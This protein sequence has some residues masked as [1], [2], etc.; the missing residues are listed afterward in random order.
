VKNAPNILQITAATRFNVYVVWWFL[1][2]TLLQIYCPLTGSGAVMRPDSFVILALL[3][4]NRLLT[5]LLP[6]LF[7]SLRIG[8]FRLQIGDLK[9][10]HFVMDAYLLAFRCARF[11]FF[12]SKPRD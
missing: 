7:T 9:R 1:V 10:S 12:S 3:Y 2:T 5:Y 8:P 6:Y 4:I 11:S